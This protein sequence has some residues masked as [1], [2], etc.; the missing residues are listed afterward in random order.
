M[1]TKAKQALA[2]ET[3]ITHEYGYEITHVLIL[4]G[5][6]E[7]LAARLDGAID[8]KA[9]YGTKAAAA[10]VAQETCSAIE[11]GHTHW[12]DSD[13]W[14][15]RVRVH[16][17]YQRYGS[18][19]FCRPHIDV[20]D[21]VSEIRGGYALVN[22]LARKAKRSM[23]QFPGS[24]EELVKALPKG[25]APIVRWGSNYLVPVGAAVAV[26]AA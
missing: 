12:F 7:P 9:G 26:K 5:K 24:P 4:S 19:S 13:M 22:K 2:Y 18:D 25:S 1:T 21:G 15:D 6:V 8:D 17:T 20:G 16:V 23:D 14:G 10:H 11:A 3:W